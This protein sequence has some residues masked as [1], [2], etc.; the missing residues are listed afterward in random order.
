LGY[1]STATIV[2]QRLSVVASDLL[3]FAGIKMYCATWPELTTT[4]VGASSKKSAI[5]AALTFLSPGLLIVDHIHFQYNGAMIGLLLVA[6]ALIRQ[7]FTDPPL[8]P[9]AAHITPPP[10]A[11]GCQ[12]RDLLGG[13]A[14][15]A[16]LCFKH[17]FLLAAPL[18]FVYLLRHYAFRPPRLG[19]D[20]DAAAVAAPGGG[21]RPRTP[22]SGDE[23]D[24]ARRFN[25]RALLALSGAVLL[26][27]A[28]AFGPFVLWADP[29]CHALLARGDGGASRSPAAAA[30]AAAAD[31][32]AQQLLAGTT[33]GA[34]LTE[35]APVAVAVPASSGGGGAFS[36]AGAGDCGLGALRQ[37]ASR[38]FPFK[39]GLVHALWAPNL[40]A[41]Y[42]TADKLA[43]RAVRWVGGLPAAR[44]LRSEAT[45]GMT[46]G[47]VGDMSFGLLPAVT[48]AF[49]AALTLLMMLPVLVDVWRRPHPRLF[50]QALAYCLLTGFMCGWHVHEK[51]ILPVLALLAICA[52]DSADAAK[53]FLFASA[54]GH[55]CLLPLLFTPAEAPV[56]HL[57]VVTF[58]FAAHITLQVFVAAD[59]RD[60]RIAS[61]GFSYSRLEAA[62]LCGLALVTAY[63][64]AGHYVCVR[65]GLFHRLRTP[66]AAAVAAGASIED[67]LPFLP[68]MLV[69][70]YGAVGLV[71]AWRLSFLA[72]RR[73]LARIN[74]YLS[75]PRV[76]PA[77]SAPA[78]PPRSKP[79]DGGGVGPAAAA[80]GFG[81]GGG[82]GAG[83]APAAAAAG[84]GQQ[85]RQGGARGWARAGL[86]EEDDDGPLPGTG[87]RGANK[88]AASANG[89]SVKGENA[90]PEFTLA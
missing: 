32:M 53:L 1:A 45:A 68:L 82:A 24:L 11:S 69:S 50:P 35:A 85:A 89:P 51:A 57:L 30:A 39:R 36:A 5:V 63:A 71:L 49:T 59:Q 6:V 34:A 78:E 64:G 43:A 21:S 48:P 13:I 27:F 12:G 55:A 29:G 38:L 14:F 4:E 26:V 87:H 88:R 10:P 67:P 22:S 65:L 76:G 61:A 15:A 37:I 56:K 75:S 83:A 9:P 16:L 8:R 52:A 25:L 81:G 23:L 80:R 18:F 19:D 42:V 73:K 3:L 46:G 33:P 54:V 40:W 17:L 41:L 90:P 72:C 44:L 28:A 60:R 74:T 66:A 77:A 7:V 2:F 62:Y 86:E 31:S 70:V 58:A 47:V 84:R 79:S 20:W